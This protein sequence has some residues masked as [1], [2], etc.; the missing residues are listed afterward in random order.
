MVNCA[1]ADYLLSVTLS[2]VCIYREYVY[3]LQHTRSSSA[4]DR[5]ELQNL[6][7]AL[8]RQIDSKTKQLTILRS[9]EQEINKVLQKS[10][11][12]HASKPRASTAR[13]AGSIKATSV[14][15]RSTSQKR[16]A[17]TH[18]QNGVDLSAHHH[19]HGEHT[20]SADPYALHH[21]HE[22]A[23]V[24]SLTQ[25]AAAGTLS[26]NSQKYLNKRIKSCKVL[27]KYCNITVCCL[28]S[29]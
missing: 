5:A 26:P 25:A 23:V 24:H 29:S 2:S 22:D 27:G 16:T 4:T 1:S 12:A 6:L 10:A 21:S 19:A 20:A 13:R 11:A 3:H 28:V 17:C 14:S 9:H 8:I 15:S 18:A 7:S